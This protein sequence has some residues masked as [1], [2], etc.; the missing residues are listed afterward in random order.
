[1]DM[2]IS[3]VCWSLT[4]HTAEMAGEIG[5]GI[6]EAGAEY[7]IFNLREG[8]ADAEYVSSSSG[9]IIGTPVYLASGVWQIHKWLGE[10]SAGINLSG[11]LGGAFA[12]AHFAQGGADTAI[13][14]IL[15]MM[16]VKGMLVYSGGGSYG[17]PFIHHGPVALDKVGDH[18]DESRS[19]FRIFGS[20]FAGKAR[21][22]F[23]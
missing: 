21:E 23:S 19:A 3:L 8:E 5:K 17:L 6:E 18:Y 16:L 10:D 11:K 2:R 12:T 4:G 7:R 14:D 9:L 13:M 22:L 1:M 20:R 15:G